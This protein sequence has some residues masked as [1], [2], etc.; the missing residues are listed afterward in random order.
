M[1]TGSTIL[2]A[3][4]CITVAGAGAWQYH[5][6]LVQQDFI[7]YDVIPCNPLE[8]SCFVYLCEEGDE[9]CDDTPYAKIEKHASDIAVCVPTSNEPCPAL[10]CG[11]NDSMCEIT[12]CSEENLEEGEECTVT[13]DYEVEEPIDGDGNEEETE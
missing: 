8:G 1:N 5:K 4:F 6:L 12:M 9:D 11:P 10:T 3:L 7:V 2:A 13:E